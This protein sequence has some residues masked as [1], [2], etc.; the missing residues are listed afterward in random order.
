[1]NLSNPYEKNYFPQSILKG[2]KFYYELLDKV[3]IQIYL[4]PN[5]PLKR[6]DILLAIDF[7]SAIPEDD[8]I[9]NLCFSHPQLT[10]SIESLEEYDTLTSD[11]LPFSQTK[12]ICSLD[13][14]LF[15]A[16][17]IMFFKAKHDI[18]K[19]IHDFSVEEK[20]KYLIEKKYYYT[21]NESSFPTKFIKDVVEYCDSMIAKFKEI[22][23]AEEANPISSEV[24]KMVESYLLLIENNIKNNDLISPLV[25]KKFEEFIA[26]LKAMLFI[27]SYYDIKADDKE[28]SFHMY[29]FAVLQGRIEGYRVSSNKESGLGRYDIILTPIE[30]RN[31]GVI[32]EI[33]KINTTR[34]E[35]ELNDALEQIEKKQYHFELK[36]AGVE[37]ILN[38]AIVFE[39]LA[40]HIKYKIG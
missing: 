17:N 24:R 2:L 35:D 12:I 6:K 30:N 36:N 33:K 38:V 37:T 14:F 27:P 1:M 11:Q 16:T 18:P 34:I 26:K 40:P 10:S 28:Q 7:L 19:V 3:N 32:I 13:H 9:N 15:T 25:E 39:G 31:T 20:I 8:N 29:L 4:E 23:E 5:F 22:R 21:Q